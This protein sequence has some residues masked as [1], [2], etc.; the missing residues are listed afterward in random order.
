MLSLSLYLSFLF[1]FD[2]NVPPHYTF[3]LYIPVFVA[4]RIPVFLL[5]RLYSMSWSFAGAYEL[6]GVAKGLTLSTM[7]I[8]FVVYMMNPDGIFTGFPRSIVLLSDYV[9]SLFLIGSFRLSRRFYFHFMERPS[10][11]GKRTLIVGA[12]NAGE[13]L[14]RDI[15]R[16][17]EGKSLHS[18]FCR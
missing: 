17:H 3:G 13:S 12:G 1:R 6:I 8:A 18:W 15:H 2:W 4:A 14:V 5:F 9:L 16:Q 11:K 10:T 7:L